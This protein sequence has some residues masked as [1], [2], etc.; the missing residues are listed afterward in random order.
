M[1]KGMRCLGRLVNCN[2]RYSHYMSLR[3]ELI[4]LCMA[5]DATDADIQPPENTFAANRL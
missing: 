1:G 3:W 5:R 2:L 4:S